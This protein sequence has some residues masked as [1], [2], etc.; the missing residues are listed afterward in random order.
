MGRQALVT[1]DHVK[2]AVAALQ[3][4]GKAVSSRSVREKL[5]NVGSMGTINKLLQKS[6]NDKEQRPDS[7]RQL[8]P[9]L[10]RSILGF[11]DKQAEDAR[12]QIAEELVGCRLEMADLAT[13][14][15][16]LCAVME[17]LRTHLAFTATEKASIEGQVAQLTSELATARKET[18]A[19]RGSSEAV[20]IDLVKLQL[21]VEAR[22]PL[23]R[24]L[25]E[26]RLQCEA[27]R[28]ACMRLEQANAVLD[29]QR[30]AL[31]R[32]VRDLRSE[33]AE[34]R[35]NSARLSEKTEKISGVLEQERAARVLAERELAV[36]SAVHP[37]RT[38]VSQRR[39]AKDPSDTSHQK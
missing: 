2:A 7:L 10:Q 8:P 19:E 4:E 5:G 35:A 30:E 23:E 15:E 22:A 13:E 25:H 12:T 24:E 28:D 29:T 26:T 17:E 27:H 14:N 32:Q 20:R 11:A 21:R 39:K 34:A 3:A 37:R 9:E 33:L 38:P 6:L 36:A 31:D 16:R 1:L 18:V